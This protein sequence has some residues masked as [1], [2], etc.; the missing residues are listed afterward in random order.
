MKKILKLFTMILAFF[1]LTITT[2]CADLEGLLGNLMPDSSTKTDGETNEEPTDDTPTIETSIKDDYDCIAIAEAIQLATEA[3]S[4]DTTESYYIYGK[5]VEVTNTTYG[6]M[7]IADET[8]ELYVYGVYS[9][10]KQTRYDAMEDKPVSGDEVVLYGKLKLFKDKPELDR[11]YL[12]AL[13][14]NKP[15]INDGDY[16]ECSVLEARKAS[17]GSLVKITGVVAQIAYAYGPV[18]CGFYL[19]DNTN[20]IYVYGEE[21]AASVAIGNTVTVAGQ[22]AYWILENEA[23]F[24]KEHGYLG[25]NQIENATLLANDKQKSNFDTTWIGETAVKD[26]METPVTEDITTTIFKVNAYVNK[27]VGTGFTNYYINDLDNYT[28]SYCYSQ[29]S[30][31]DFAWLDEFDGKICTVY[32]S[33]INA[34]SSAAGCVWR[35]LPVAVMDEGYEFDV[36]NAPGYA[37]KYFAEDQFLDSYTADPALEVITN[38]DAEHLGFTGVSVTYKS[39][40][41]DVAYF[42]NVNNKVVFHTKDVESG[43]AVI[44]ITATYNG[45]AMTVLH[46]ITVSKPLEFTTITVNEAIAKVDAE[47]GSEVVVKGIVVSSLVNRV[48]FYIS[49]DTGII[50]VLADEAQVSLLTPGD[51][52]VVKGVVGRSKKEGK[53]DLGQAH[54]NGEI[55]ENY[56][57]NHAYN[58]SYFDTTKQFTDLI[59]LDVAK[60]YSTKV[61][62]VQAKIA[63][64]E[65][66]FFTSLEL[67]DAND[68]S[69]ELQLYCENAGQY[70]FLNA[71][72]NE[73]VTLELAL[74]DWNGSG[75]KGCVIS[76]TG[77]DGNKVI[78][79]LNFGK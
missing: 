58:T 78:N 46:K 74:C 37:I 65:T 72:A 18:P 42:E 23:S 17:A 63:L 22:K 64:I 73:T 1:G 48:G 52:V 24:A 59:G 32:L 19:V 51:E 76:A 70:A 41:P 11:G 71:F 35:L 26:I 43:E 49:D 61:Y 27:V 25:C 77:A 40:N 28:G 69:K 3:G 75:W 30:G 10:D 33:A 31:A 6:E 14:H 68:S 9:A 56:H 7:T 5:I 60:D 44:E 15:E 45:N 57:G 55:L 47:T 21:I 2:G 79:T 4:D 13:K 66:Q 29:C 20:S 12:Q 50:A 38:V 67:V 16:E 8:G 39:H 54:I 36:K 62:V 34:K 53:P